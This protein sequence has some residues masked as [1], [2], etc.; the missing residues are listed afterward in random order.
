M[1]V[2]ET[3]VKNHEASYF[4]GQNTWTN[5]NSSRQIAVRS[6]LLLTYQKTECKII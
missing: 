5:S 1:K 2:S 6:I 4:N 3:F